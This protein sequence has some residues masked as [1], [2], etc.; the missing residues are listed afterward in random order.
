MRR[1]K[2]FLAV[3]ATVA[4]VGAASLRGRI[5]RYAVAEDSMRPLL[6]PGDYVIAQRSAGTPWRGSV[7]VFPHPTRTGFELVKRVVGLAGERVT[8]ANGQVHI[9]GTVL[10]EPWA[11]GITR[12]DGEWL[13]GPDEVFVLGDRRAA[14]VDDSRTLG[15][16]AAVRWKLVARYWPP[17]GIGLL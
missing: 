2:G 5:R 16:V 8:I 13:V 4:V 17:A 9:D 14:S 11:D 3:V 10:A 12:P 1:R 6:R 15:P 7:V